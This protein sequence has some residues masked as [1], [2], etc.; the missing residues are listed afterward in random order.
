MHQHSSGAFNGPLK[1]QSISL[2]FDAR[3]KPFWGARNFLTCSRA[4][5]FRGYNHRNIDTQ[6]RE[7]S[8]VSDGFVLHENISIAMIQHKISG[9]N[10]RLM[11]AASASASASLVYVMSCEPLFDVASGQASQVEHETREQS[12][13]QKHLQRNSSLPLVRLEHQM[14]QCCCMR[15]TC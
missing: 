13:N 9:D 11:I 14:A 1:S 12:R 4:S 7:Q 5:A 15:A 2:N 3:A 6:T 8:R 10:R